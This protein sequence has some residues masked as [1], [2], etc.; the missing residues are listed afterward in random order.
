LF[1]FAVLGFPILLAF[2][3][4]LQPNQGFVGCKALF[5]EV[6]QVYSPGYLFP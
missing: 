4:L 5:S 1:L 6:Q 3:L 2:K